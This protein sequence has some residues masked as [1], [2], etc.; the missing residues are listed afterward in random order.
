MHVCLFATALLVVF[1]WLS[2]AAEAAVFGRSFSIPEYSA[3]L[4][5]LS[6][7]ATHAKDNPSA[8]DIAINELR[9]AWIVESNGQVFEVKTA[10]MVDQF[11]QLKKNPASDAR[12]RLLERINAMKTDAQLFKQ[13][14]PDS[15]GSRSALESILARSEFHQVHG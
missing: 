11:E 10:W 1:S 6:E 15:S 8:A 3:E 4:N 2:T 9:G 5:H 14:P 12:D 7:L 13:T